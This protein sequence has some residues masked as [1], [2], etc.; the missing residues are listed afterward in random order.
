MRIPSW[1]DLFREKKVIAVGIG[2][3]R[4][5]Y[6][7]SPYFLLR[8]ST[9]LPPRFSKLSNLVELSSFPSTSTHT[10]SFEKLFSPADSTSSKVKLSFAPFH[11]TTP[12]LKN[13]RIEFAPTIDNKFDRSFLSLRLYTFSDTTSSEATRIYNESYPGRS[14]ASGLSGTRKRECP[15]VDIR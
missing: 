14:N 7:I 6:V 9:S 3:S 13:P 12:R 10:P 8:K 4:D 15:P 5:L 1:K 2:P 11:R